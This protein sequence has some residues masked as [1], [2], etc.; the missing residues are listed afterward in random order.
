[1]PMHR[2][3]RSQT[4]GTVAKVMKQI[5]DSVRR[6]YSRETWKAAKWLMPRESIL[7]RGAPKNWQSRRLA[8]E[9]RLWKQ[10]VTAEQD[11]LNA[12]NA[13]QEAVIKRD[14]AHQKLH[15][16]GIPEEEITAFAKSNNEADLSILRPERSRSRAELSRAKL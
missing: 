2:P 6:G 5:G 1:M 4:S 10:K 16:I 14:L 13:H 11:Y 15:T 8:R 9:E 7:R 12:K 3:G